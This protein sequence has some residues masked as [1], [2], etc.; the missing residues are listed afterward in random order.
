MAVFTPCHATPAGGECGWESG[1]EGLV[2]I[3]EVL[4]NC[5]CVFLLAC[6]VMLE[7]KR[8]NTSQYV[9]QQIIHSNEDSSSQPWHWSVVSQCSS[10]MDCLDSL[11]FSAME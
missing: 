9:F 11:F 10:L 3:D 1:W 5:G 4:V 2:K 6:W 8:N 7:G